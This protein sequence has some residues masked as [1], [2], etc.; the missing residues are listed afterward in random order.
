M[1]HGKVNRVWK[2]LAWYA[3]GFIDHFIVNAR[4]T[5][6]LWILISRQLPPNA[7]WSGYEESKLVNEEKFSKITPNVTATLLYR[8]FLIDPFHIL[9]SQK[10]IIFIVVKKKERFRLV[11]ILHNKKASFAF[12]RAYLFPHENNTFF[13]ALHGSSPNFFWNSPCLCEL[14]KFWL[15]IRPFELGMRA[16]PSHKYMYIH[17][18]SK[19]KLAINIFQQ[20]T[21]IC[22]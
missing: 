19:I 9:V 5:F 11:I 15:L 13:F 1:E 22:L 10:S 21:S 17:A 16:Y 12:P 3:L 18:T 8:N 2:S 20:I 4:F 7:G 6:V 14:S